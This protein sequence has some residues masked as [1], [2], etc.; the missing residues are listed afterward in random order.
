MDILAGLTQGFAIALEPM[1]LFWCFIGVF[2]GTV[3]GVLPGLG[4]SATVALLL[5]LS[6]TSRGEAAG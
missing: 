2:F 4:P 1:N 3:V 5:P 6:R